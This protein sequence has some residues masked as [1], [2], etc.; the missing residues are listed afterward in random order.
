MIGT[1]RWPISL[2]LTSCARIRTKAMVVEISRSPEPSRIAFRVSRDGVGTLKLFARRCGTKPPSAVRR[3][4]RYLAS[5]EPSSG[6]KNG[7][8]SSSLSLTGMSKRSR[9]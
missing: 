1:M 7:R 6:L 2:S 9:K 8:F 3:S 5:A 4:A